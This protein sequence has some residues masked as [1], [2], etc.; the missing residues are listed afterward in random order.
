MS[1][2][3]MHAPNLTLDQRRDELSARVAYFAWCLLRLAYTPM[4]CVPCTACGQ[5]GPG[6]W[7]NTCDVQGNHPILLHPHLT[8]PLC[9]TCVADNVTCPICRIT[10]EDGPAEIDFFGPEPPGDGDMFTQV[11]GYSGP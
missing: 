11:A 8:A 6:D 4:Q 9:R 2:P 1:Y 7:C 5:P 10:P 3:L